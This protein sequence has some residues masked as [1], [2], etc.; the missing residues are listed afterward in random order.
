[1]ENH[2]E[3]QEGSSTHDVNSR[4]DSAYS[5]EDAMEFNDDNS[6]SAGDGDDNFEDGKEENDLSALNSFIHTTRT[7]IQSLLL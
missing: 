5:P 6:D 3:N 7:L 1:M 2:K 4:S